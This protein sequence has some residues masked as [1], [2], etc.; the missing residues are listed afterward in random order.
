M[1]PARKNTPT[2]NANLSLWVAA[3]I[4]ATKAPAKVPSACARNGK[5]KCFGSNKCMAAFKPSVVVTSAPSGGGIMEPLTWIRPMFTMLPVT[6]PAIT[7]KMFLRMGCMVWFA[8]SGVCYSFGL[9]VCFNVLF[10]VIQ[11][12][13]PAGALHF[14]IVFVFRIKGGGY[15]CGAVQVFKLSGHL[16]SVG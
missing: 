11:Y 15:F 12:C 13:L 10:K 4:A 1:P 2:A 8:G 14:H 6:M 3:T 16:S 5:I 7:A 9:L